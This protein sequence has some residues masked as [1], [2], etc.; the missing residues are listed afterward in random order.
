MTPNEE[1][2][3]LRQIYAAALQRDPEEREDYLD[4]V[5]VGNP[6]LHAKVAAL[7]EAHSQDFPEAARIPDE[8]ARRQTPGTRSKAR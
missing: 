2:R 5:C 6:E 4:R 3:Q 8:V 7:L 1:S